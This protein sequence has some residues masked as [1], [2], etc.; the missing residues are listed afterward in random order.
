VVITFDDAYRDTLDN[1][2]PILQRYGYPATLFV[3]TGLV[4]TSDQY[5]D[6]QQLQIMR[7]GNITMANHTVSHTHL[8]RKLPDESTQA[9]AQRIKEEVEVAQTA[10][11]KHLGVTRKIFAYPYGEYNGA[12]VEM[13][14]ALDYVAFGQQSGAIG[15]ASD[16]AFLPRFPLSGA[17]TD[18]SQF[19]TKTATLALPL[20]RDFID[21]MTLSVRPRLWL[22]L[23]N[24]DLSLHRLACYG[25]GGSAHI[26]HINPQEII[27]TPTLDIPVGRSRY[28]CTLRHKSGRY[29]WFSQPW[30]R[31][32]VDGSWY[33][34]P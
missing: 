3:A 23:H 25:P 12:V 33:D 30:I 28:N 21:P 24:T 11:N 9:W 17:Y 16:T 18:M 7:D 22:K 29:Y 27:A 26:E 2:L 14:R 31:K 13:I 34:E 10:L 4:G 32:N 19:K 1:A 5:L 6:W 8:L 15:K 20:T